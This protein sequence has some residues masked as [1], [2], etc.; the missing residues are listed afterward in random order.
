MRDLFSKYFQI[1]KL[2]VLDPLGP[3]SYC[4]F[5]RRGRSGYARGFFI[6]FI[7]FFLVFCSVNLTSY[8]FSHLGKALI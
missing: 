3:L 8:C 7:S 5:L 4:V 2:L 6:F 1:R